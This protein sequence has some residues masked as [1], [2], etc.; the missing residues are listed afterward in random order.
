MSTVS[1]SRAFED[2]NDSFQTFKK[3]MHFSCTF[4]LYLSEE[5]VLGSFYFSFIII[6]NYSLTI[7]GELAI[8]TQ[9]KENVQ[10]S[11][12]QILQTV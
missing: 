12:G 10:Q 5:I 9:V 11:D 4:S 7:I 3:N 2:W 1:K 6:L 8:E